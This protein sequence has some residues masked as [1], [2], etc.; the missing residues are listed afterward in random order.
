MNQADP[1]IPN[2][3]FIGQEIKWDAPWIEVYLWVGCPSG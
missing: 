3:Y 2:S 1:A